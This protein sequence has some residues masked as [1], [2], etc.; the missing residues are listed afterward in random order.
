MSSEGRN[1]QPTTE[2]TP[3]T[4]VTGNNAGT[5]RTQTN[6]RNNT[7]T[8]R[9]GNDREAGDNR[10]SYVEHLPTDY[11]GKNVEVGAILALK[12]E[13]FSKKVVYSVF[14]EKL[15]NYVLQKFDDAKDMIPILEKM[16]DPKNDIISKQPIDLTDTEKNSQVQKW[17]KQEQ[18]KKFIKRLTTLE[19]NKETLFGIVWGQCSTAVQEVIKADNDYVTKEADFDCIWLLKNANWSRQASMIGQTNITLYYNP[20]S[21]SAPSGKEQMNQMIHIEHEWMQMP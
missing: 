6:T 2:T 4:E 14:I 5:P 11:L 20:Y 13:R 7:G 21:N 9:T 18:V 10:R 16:S 15:K 8:T 12:N 1:I 3:Q 19:N 17:I